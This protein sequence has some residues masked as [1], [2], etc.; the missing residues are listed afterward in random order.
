MHPG[1]KWRRTAIER[2]GRLLPLSDN[3]S[4]IDKQTGLSVAQLYKDTGYQDKPVW[5]V[6][7]RSM[8][9]DGELK[10]SIMTWMED[11]TKAREYA[12]AQTDDM[13]YV[14]KHK[15]TKE[16]ILARAGVRPMPTK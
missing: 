3:W 6:I 16:E 8:N 5:R 2:N 14:V 4:L 1:R 12:E 11:P 7:C 9:E 15:R 10:D 13:R